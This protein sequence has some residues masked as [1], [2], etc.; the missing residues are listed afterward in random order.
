[1]SKTNILNQSGKGSAP[2]NNFSK[3]FR[4]NFDS[5]FGVKTKKVCPHGVPIGGDCAE[6]LK[7]MPLEKLVNGTGVNRH[8]GKTW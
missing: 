5:I 7:A 1:M 4:N 3:S 6:C 8:E 2:R